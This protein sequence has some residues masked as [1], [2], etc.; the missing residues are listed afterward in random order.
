MAS[1]EGLFGRVPVAVKFLQRLLFQ[2]PASGL[3]LDQFDSR[4][5]E[6][7]YEQLVGVDEKGIGIWVPMGDGGMEYQL[8][9]EVPKR[10]GLLGG[11][12]AGTLLNHLFKHTN[13][14]L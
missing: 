6:I 1:P 4:L 8:S 7:P 3:N 12:N 13:E 10:L 11:R 5:T 2:I 9:H 14:S